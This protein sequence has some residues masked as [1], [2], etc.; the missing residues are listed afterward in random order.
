MSRKSIWP[1]AT[2][3]W[4]ICDS[5][6]F[7]E[8]FFP[9][10]V[11]DHADADEEAGPGCGADRVENAEGEAQ[12]VVEAAAVEI[13]AVVGG[14]RPELIDEMAV[15]VEGDAVKAGFLHACRGGSVIGDD[16]FDVPLLRFLGEGAVR[17]LADR[18]RG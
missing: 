7:G 12:A 15:S 13:G 4:A 2:R 3:R 16:P 8:A 6:G 9:V 11:G 10:L 17:G 1:L 5:F 18:R 14:R